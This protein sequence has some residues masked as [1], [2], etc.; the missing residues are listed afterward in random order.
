MIDIQKLKAL[1]VVAPTGPW[2]A[3]NDSLY[4]KDDGYTRHLLDTDAGHDVEDAAYYAALT[5]I[6]AANPAAVLEL[7]AEVERLRSSDAFAAGVQHADEAATKYI[8]EHWR[9]QR[10]ELKVENEALHKDAARYHYLAGKSWMEWRDGGM[11]GHY[12]F[13]CVAKSS[14]PCGKQKGFHY[15]TTDDAIDAAI[16]KDQQP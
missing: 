16:T 2:M 5:F 4:F 8:D 9:V 11:S 12:R 7:I 14:A 13:P 10:D 6:A 1:A 15:A 3:E